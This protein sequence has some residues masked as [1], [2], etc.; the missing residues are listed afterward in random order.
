MGEHPLLLLIGLPGSGKSTFAAQLTQ[1]DQ[2][3]RL[4]STDRIRE[5][6]FGSEATQ[7]DW[8]RI[9]HEI[10]RQFKAA[11]AHSQP[12]S[13]CIVI[14]DAT[15]ARRR[16]RRKLI[17][18]A[19]HC[20]FNHITGVWFDTPLDVCL[21]RNRKRDRQVPDEIILQMHRR[22]LGG[23]PDLSDGLDELIIHRNQ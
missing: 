7:G 6:L 14:Y 4:I 17:L 1:Q 10:Q 23:P 21:E 3:Y 20:G 5:A 15:N 12:G 22:L 8:M 16:D 2:Q 13:A 11:I 19:R 9:W 18:L